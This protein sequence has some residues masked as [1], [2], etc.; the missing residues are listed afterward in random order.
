MSKINKWINIDKL[1]KKYGIGANSNNLVIDWN[2]SIGIELEFIYANV[3]GIIKIVNY[4]KNNITILYND[5]EYIV[6][7]DQLRK[8]LLGHILGLISSDFKLNIN[9]ILCDNKRNIIIIDREYR[10]VEK[11]DKKGRKSIAHTKWYKYHCNKCNNEDWVIEHALINTNVGCS[12]CCSSPKKL[13]ENVNDIPTTAPW[14]IPYFIGGYEEAKGYFKYSRDRIDMVC[15]FCNTIHKNVSIH[16]VMNNHGLTCACQD[17]WSYPNKFMFKFLDMLGVE[18]STEKRFDWSDGRKYDDYIELNEK[19]III[20]NHGRFHYR[21]TKFKDARRNYSQEVDNDI[22]KEQLAKENGIDEYIIIDCEFSDPVYIKNSIMNSI[23]P[24]LFSFTEESV[25][26]NKCDKFATSN[27]VKAVCEYKNNN[28]DLFTYDI[29]NIFK[30][31]QSTIIKYLTKGNKFGWCHYDKKEELLR[32]NS[33]SNKECGEIPIYCSDL[34]MYFRSAVYFT[35]YYN[36]KY[37]IYINSGC[38]RNCCTGKQ[39]HTHNLHFQ[40]ITREEFNQIKSNPLTSHLVYGDFF[41]IQ[42]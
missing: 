7:S 18:F 34:E 16:N 29:G 38:V 42:N 37:N 12:A 41:N 24:N 39:L 8:C 4:N 3:D 25:D 14:M 20:E 15:P 31:S 36:E 9:D 5:S 32:A 19:Q 21:E 10:D 27:I 35:K 6:T 23:L 1:P 28:P 33:K 30:L 2:N 26:W 13:V 40:Y 17:G 11:T 22:Y